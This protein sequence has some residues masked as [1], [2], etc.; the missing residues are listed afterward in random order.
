MAEL[1]AETKNMDFKLE[2]VQDFNAHPND[3]S[4]RDLL[5]R[6]S[7]PI[8]LKRLALP[9]TSEQKTA[10]RKFFF[11]YKNEN[12]KDLISELRKMNRPDLEPEAVRE[13]VL[14]QKFIDNHFTISG[15]RAQT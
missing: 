5:F 6:I 2:Q 9:E 4:H 11:W 10:Q 13:K 12:R 15:I 8:R 14:K 7:H 3:F 1:A